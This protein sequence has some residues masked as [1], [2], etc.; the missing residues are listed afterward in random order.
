MRP[1]LTCLTLVSVDATLYRGPPAP[2]ASPALAPV[3]YEPVPAP[4]VHAV[5]AVPAPVHLGHHGAHHGAHLAHP[6][7]ILPS[8]DVKPH[9][10]V[11]HKV[12]IVI[13]FLK[14]LSKKS[15]DVSCSE[16]CA[17]SSASSRV[18]G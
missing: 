16:L 13:Y 10:V 8:Y 6:N 9:H 7:Y 1:R 12:F 2:T 4:S 17:S 15:G 11:H 14:I 5:H 18:P 3:D